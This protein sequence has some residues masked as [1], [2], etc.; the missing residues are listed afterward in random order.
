MELKSIAHILTHHPQTPLTVGRHSVMPHAPFLFRALAKPQS[1]CYTV[2]V[3]QSVVKKRTLR[4]S[5]K[6]HLNKT[7]GTV[8][9]V[10]GEIWIDKSQ[11]ASEID[12]PFRF[13]GKE[14][15]VETGLYYY[16]ARYL[17]SKTSRWLSADPALGEYIPG[18]PINDEA[19]KRNGNLPGM[20]GV[21]N[22]VNFHLYHY[23]GNNPIKYTDPDGKE[24][25][26]N[27]IK[28]IV[29]HIVNYEM[30]KTGNKTVDAVNKIGVGLIKI[31]VGNLLAEGGIEGGAAIAAGSSG[32]LT[33]VGGAVAVA[34]VAAGATMTIAGAVDVIDGTISLM[35]GSNGQKGNDEFREKTKGANANDRQQVDS[36]AKETNIDRRKFGDFIEKMKRSENRGGS[37]NYT[38]KELQELA[39]EFKE[40]K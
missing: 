39:K 4:P 40:L 14:R 11:A 38:Y 32:A 24:S 37:D 33:V 3:M 23:A 27:T 36:V 26:P 15:D 2:F 17:D 18:A 28:N 29:N 12:V 25:V 21:F 22:V 19:K 5:P 8:S 6:K 20:G 34:G 31:G 16:G 7:A 35:Q 30:P 10:G 9:S 13:T 1:V